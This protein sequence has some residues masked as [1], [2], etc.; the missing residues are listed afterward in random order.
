MYRVPTMLTKY[1]Y[2]IKVQK[3]IDRV[4]NLITTRPFAG[5]SPRILL[6]FTRRRTVDQM[7]SRCLNWV[8]GRIVLRCCVKIVIF[9]LKRLLAGLI[10]VLLRGC[11]TFIG[12]PLVAVLVRR[13][14][15]VRGNVVGSLGAALVPVVRRS[16]VVLDVGSLVG[17]RTGRDRLS[18][19]RIRF[20]RRRG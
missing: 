17:I 11:G 13:R 10:R 6:T 1:K 4:I 3:S 16:G 12:R 18:G 5:P 9:A 2:I 15:T 7:V 19:T 20:E 14:A 8:V